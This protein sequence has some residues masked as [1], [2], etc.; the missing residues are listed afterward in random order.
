MRSWKSKEGNVTI[1][2]ALICPQENQFALYKSHYMLSQFPPLCQSLEIKVSYFQTFRE[3][4][5]LRVRVW[6]R[7]EE[8]PEFSFE[9][10]GVVNKNMDIL[11]SGILWFFLRGTFDFMIYDY[12]CVGTNFDQKN[13]F[14]PLFDPLADWTRALQIVANTIMEPRR[15]LWEV[16]W[17]CISK[18]LHH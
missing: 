8:P 9:L 4:G 7:E 18:P 12:I 14:D 3:S 6:A 2:A 15:Q 1:L 17:I 13:V 16:N 5:K 11:R 10:R